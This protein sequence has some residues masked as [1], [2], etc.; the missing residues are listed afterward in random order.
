M[1][2]SEMR[3]EASGWRST[4]GVW[5]QTARPF[6]LSAAISPILVGTAVAAYDGRF[7]ALL[8]AAAL[9]GSVFLQVA[10]NY[11][12]EYFDYRYQLDT[13]Q[14]LGASTAIFRG[15]M[16]ARQVF[17]AG[18]LSVAIAAAFGLYLVARVGPPVLLFG[19]AAVTI[20]YFYSAWP[21]SL[22]QRGLGDL[23]VFLAMG[24]LM[25]WGAYYVQIPRW[26]WPAFA[27]SVPVGLLVV[28]IL[29][30]NNLRDYA[31]DLAV[32]KRTLVVR[33]GERFG[34]R[35]EAALIIGAFVAAVIAVAARLLPVTAVIVGIT[36]PRALDLV[37][38]V[39]TTTSRRDFIV[40]MRRIALLHLTFGAALAAGIALATLA[41]P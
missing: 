16:T 12:N 7:D 5:I 24:L 35:Y 26:S 29:D 13:A 41:R 22:A 33:F 1:A 4:L 30:M 40:G 25:V 2:Q 27:A 32:R 17:A 20:L 34:R 39:L 36:L 37:R 11:F 28:A 6:S 18:A 19:V 10:A 9:I 15:A 23:F 38:T 8:F 21:L 31:D 14:S 3:A